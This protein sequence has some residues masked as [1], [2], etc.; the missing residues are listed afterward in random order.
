MT[1]PSKLNEMLYT[2]S[3]IELEVEAERADILMEMYLLHRGQ[4][5]NYKQWEN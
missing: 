1:F 4:V 2:P 5:N 3:K